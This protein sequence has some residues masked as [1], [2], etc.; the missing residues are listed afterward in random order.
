MDCFETGSC[1]QWLASS[2]IGGIIS[3]TN[4]KALLAAN[5]AQANSQVG[6]DSIQHDGWV[7][8]SQLHAIRGIYVSEFKMSHRKH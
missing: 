4:D 8:E 2:Y 3:N 1:C 7:D 6:F 5:T